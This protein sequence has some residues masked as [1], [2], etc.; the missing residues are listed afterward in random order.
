M[1]NKH[2]R[3]VADGL[4]LAVAMVWG[5]SYGITKTTLLYVPVLIFLMLRFGL[6]ALLLLPSIVQEIRHSQTNLPHKLKVGLVT[7]LVLLTIFLLEVFGVAFTTAS[8]ASFLISLFV[9][10]TPFV[11][12]WLLKIKPDNQLFCVSILCLI[13][14]GL[15]TGGLSAPLNLGDGLIFL[16]GLCRAFMVV[17]TK[18]LTQKQAIGALFL[19]G[20]QSL[21]VWLGTLLLVI[22]THQHLALP[23]DTKFWWSLGYLV[24]FCSIFAFFAQNFAIKP[25]TPTRVSILLGTEPVFG[26]LFAVVW[27]QESLSWLSWI[28]GL[29]IVVSSIYLTLQKSN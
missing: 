16:A 12:W 21:I 3:L 2:T 11:E 14:T 13:G 15:I 25:T 8:N 24:I 7:G 19:T 17:L 18:K 23:T 20:I 5:T 9:V 26:A 29:L 22:L 28:G 4:L 6:T 27:L 10:F 1:I